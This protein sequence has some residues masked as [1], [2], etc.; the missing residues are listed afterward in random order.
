MGGWWMTI[1]I[2][3]RYDLT[4]YLHCLPSYLGNRGEVWSQTSKS[5][6]TSDLPFWSLQLKTRYRLFLKM[7]LWHFYNRFVIILQFYLLYFSMCICDLNSDLTG[8]CGSCSTPHYC[9]KRCF[10]PPVVCRLCRNY[11]CGEIAAQWGP[12][13]GQ[14]RQYRGGGGRKAGQCALHHV[15]RLWR[16]RRG[17]LCCYSQ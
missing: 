1:T 5:T 7:D 13:Y 3:F 12:G 8:D 9:A 16:T 11:Q 17:W 15:R 6:V 10:H 4:S 14:T 2:C